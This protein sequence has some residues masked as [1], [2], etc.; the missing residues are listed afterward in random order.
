[1]ADVSLYAKRFWKN[2]ALLRELDRTGGDAEE[3]QD[4]INE[5]TANALHAPTEDLRR[6]SQAA[7]NAHYAQE[8][9]NVRSI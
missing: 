8:M 2:S 5:L 7:I 3:I 4:C 6:R 1:M 9:Q